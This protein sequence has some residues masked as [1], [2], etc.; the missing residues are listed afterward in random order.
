MP[1]ASPPPLRA[2]A[3][4]QVAV[5]G[6]LPEMFEGR[7]DVDIDL[8]AHVAPAPAEGV[9]LGQIPPG[10]GIDHAV[11]KQPVQVRLRVV[12]WAV[13]NVIE[14]RIALHHVVDHLPLDAHEAGRRLRHF[15]EAV[16]VDKF[17]GG[18][19]VID[20]IVRKFAVAQLELPAR[21]PLREAALRPVEALHRIDGGADVAVRQQRPADRLRPE[22]DIRIDPE[23]V[24]QR[25]VLEELDHH[26][27]AAPGDEAFGMHVQ[28]MIE[29]EALGV[30]GQV[31][32]AGYVVHADRRDVAGGRE[33]DLHG[34]E[35]RIGKHGLGAG[36]RRAVRPF[37]G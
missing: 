8:A 28:D 18:F 25:L 4:E 26:L 10:I 6:H 32:D 2:Q 22:R 33:H 1:C 21:H 5:I 12:R 24:G 14:L 37:V 27:V 29:P 23:E 3:L 13:G 15:D 30:V 11:E 36:W 17:A 16:G 20:R 9:I 31:E 19:A 7:V 35:R 34:L